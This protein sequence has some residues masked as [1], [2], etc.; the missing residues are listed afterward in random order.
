MNHL[1]ELDAWQRVAYIFIRP[2]GEPVTDLQRVDARVALL[3]DDRVGVLRGGEQEVATPGG[4]VAAIS[5]MRLSGMTP[6]PLGI[7]ETSP[8]AEAP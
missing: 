1:H 5:A 4:T 3:R 8:N 7:V 6:G 2:A